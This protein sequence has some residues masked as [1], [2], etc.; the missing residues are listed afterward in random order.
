MIG[1]SLQAESDK[2]ARSWMQHD[3]GVL[4]GY[5]VAG[6][7]DPRLN[8]QSILSRH[9]LARALTAERFSALMEAEYRFAAVMNWLTGFAGRLGDAGDLE[10]VLYALGRG[11]D[12]AEGIEIPGF[13]VQTFAGLPAT[14]G[15]LT[16]PNYIESFLSG[17]RLVRGRAKLH[18]P[19]LETFRKLWHKALK[20]ES[21]VRT[22]PHEPQSRAVRLA[23]PVQDKVNRNSDSRKGGRRDALPYVDG[24]PVQGLQALSAHSGNS[25]SVLEP[26]CGSA[27]DYRFL[28]AYGLARLV[29]YTGF[30]L[31]AKNV[32]NARALFPGISFAV[33]NVFEIAAPD[34]A[35]D[36]CYVHDLFE[37]LSLEG[38]RVA[39]KEVCRVTRQGLCVGFFNMDEIRD[40]Q[41][42]PVDEYHWNLLSMARMREQFADCGFTAQVVHIGA[43]LRQQIGCEQ[44]HN[45]NA[46]TLL[47]SPA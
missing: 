21:A 47:L 13:V 16:I 34:K 5:L 12:N 20:A 4:R 11:A 29:D 45:P 24:S 39:V 40:H 18:N 36:L 14:A 42:R 17:T 23:C 46:Y 2:L 38:M 44:T 26:A 30:D 33:G 27:N 7:E 28:H 35:F 25:L 43:F 15:G 19:S 9:F 8:L 41:A 6:V 32:E 31:C 10:L 1:P 37:H 22:P 3:A